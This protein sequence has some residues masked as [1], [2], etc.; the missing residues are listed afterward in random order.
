MPPAALATE[1][2][3]KENNAVRLYPALPSA[4]PLG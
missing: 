4:V 1:N 3:N 2:N